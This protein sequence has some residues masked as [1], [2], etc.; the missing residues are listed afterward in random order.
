M[1]I[2]ENYKRVLEKIAKAAESSGRKKEDITLIA[3]TKNY[4]LEEILPLYNQ[5]LRNFGENRLQEAY[6]KIEKAPSDIRWHMIGSLQKNKVKNAIQKFVLIHGVH[7]LELAKKISEC[8]LELKTVTSILLQ[9]NTSG[10][11][12]KQG[13]SEKT[14]LESFQTILKLPSLKIAGLM[15]MAPLTDDKKMIRECFADLRMLKDCLNEL[16]IPHSPMKILSMGMS[17]DYDLAIEEGA[18]LI[19]VGSALMRTL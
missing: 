2:E 3:V 12:T 1:T 4:S 5:G 6:P 17:N 8:S 7:S 19:R 16:F 9:V 15:T 14:V 18:T 13:F 11:A 10:E